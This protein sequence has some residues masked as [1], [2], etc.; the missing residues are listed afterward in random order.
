MKTPEQQKLLPRKELQVSTWD[1]NTAA[2]VNKTIA[3]RLLRDEKSLK[4]SLRNPIRKKSAVNTC[5]AQ[6]A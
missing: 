1:R 2:K 6:R 5:Q 3:D 4:D